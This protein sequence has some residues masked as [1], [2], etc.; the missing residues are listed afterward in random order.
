MKTYKLNSSKNYF[1]KAKMSNSRNP[2]LKRC[3]VAFLCFI[4]LMY[5]ETVAQQNVQF[6]QYMYNT[7]AVNPA[8][9]G[10]RGVL[11]ASLLARMQWV[12]IEGAPRT[13]TF[14]VHSPLPKEKMG[15]GL[16][17]TND[18]IG[19]LNSTYIVGSY[20]YTVNLNMKSKLSFGT[21]AGV[22]AMQLK[23]SEITINEQNDQLFAN[24]RASRLRPNFGFGAY[25]HTDMFYTGIS[26]PKLLQNKIAGT[27]NSAIE[28]RHLYWICGGIFSINSIWKV[29]PTTMVKFTKNAPIS[30]DM[31]VNFLFMDKLWLGLNHRIKD[32]FSGM[33]GYNLTDQLQAGYAYDHTITALQKYN[34]GSHE[35][36]LSYDFFFNKSKLKSPRYF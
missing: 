31:S 5:K 24:A 7:L 6:T 29:K 3:I 36:F 33:V 35:V 23:A 9:A 25:Y 13:Q 21:S 22:N 32:S 19:P 2:K 26:T 27:E 28:Q 30:V 34:S 15:V 17:I 14:Y 8:Y 12:G 10:S 16:N 1:N 11:N 4:L 20:S 18:K